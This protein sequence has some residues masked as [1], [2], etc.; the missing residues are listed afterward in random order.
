MLDKTVW[1]N[2][3]DQNLLVVIIVHLALVVIHPKNIWMTD[4]VW[5]VGDHGY[6]YFRPNFVSDDISLN[7]TNGIG[8]WSRLKWR[9]AGGYVIWLW[10][11][12]V[13]DRCVVCCQ[14]KC[15]VVINCWSDLCYWISEYSLI[16]GLSQC[17][18][19]FFFVHVCHCVYNSLRKLLYHIVS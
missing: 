7:P 1:L 18:D 8:N 15:T 12:P 4:T 11:P 19:R 2:S 3:M 13:C 17:I 5:R 16:F 14:I 9:R 6:S 10:L